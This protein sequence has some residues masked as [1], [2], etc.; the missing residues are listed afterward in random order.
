[1][2]QYKMVRFKKYIYIVV[3]VVITTCE[4]MVFLE[5]LHIVRAEHIKYLAW[6]LQQCFVLFLRLLPGF[7]ILKGTHRGVQE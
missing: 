4:A 7:R 3:F 6:L 5:G 2:L 1:M